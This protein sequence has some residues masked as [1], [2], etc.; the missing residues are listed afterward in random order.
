MVEAVVDAAAAFAVDDDA[1]AVVDLDTPV[2]IDAA[3]HPRLRRVQ[4][5]VDSERTHD[6]PPPRPQMWSPWSPM[7]YRPNTKKID[8]RKPPNPSPRQTSF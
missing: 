6:L 4:S 2:D 5:L 1:F 8:W 7:N 3:A